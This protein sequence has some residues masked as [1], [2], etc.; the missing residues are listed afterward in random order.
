MSEF[1]H[2]KFK[3]TAI[4]FEILTKYVVSSILRN[5]RDPALS[6]IK[7]AFQPH[8]ELSKELVLYK[9]IL[10]FSKKKD[11]AVA[12]KYL[13]IILEQ[14][15]GLDKEKLKKEKYNLLGE[16]K[17]SFNEQ[18]FFNSRITNYGLLASIYKLFENSSAQA[19]GEYIQNF[20]VIL[21]GMT[22]APVTEKPLTDSMKI[23]ESQPDEIKKLAFQMVIEKFN[24]KYTKLSVKQKKL[25]SKFINEN[26]DSLEFKNYVL[27]EC[28]YI[29]TKLSDI[30]L[31]N[32]TLQIKV[33]E[34]KKLL[35]EIVS[36]KFIK[37][38]HLTALLGYYELINTLK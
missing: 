21:E 26:P 23:W 10:E 8:S 38:E 2:T 33:G 17:K 1:K 9:N 6:I 32:Q 4:I 14:R 34:I 7:K 35:S 12:S 22:G 11:K 3:N 36:A 20:E 5:K 30:K 31:E 29:K 13:D 19:P 27:T 28:G 16:I 15:S 24:S 18:E 25:I 37:E